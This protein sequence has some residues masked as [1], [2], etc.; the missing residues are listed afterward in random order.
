MDETQQ[1]RKSYTLVQLEAY[2]QHESPYDFLALPHITSFT[3]RVASDELA[4]G[5][6][7]AATLNPICHVHLLLGQSTGE[8]TDRSPVYLRLG[9]EGNNAFGLNCSGR[10]YKFA[11]DNL[12]YVDLEAPFL[13]L[14]KNEKEII[15]LHDSEK[16]RLK[17]WACYLFLK[18]GCIKTVRDYPG[19]EDDLR[20]A[21]A[22]LAKEGGRPVKTARQK[23]A[24]LRQK[25][26]T[27]KDKTESLRGRIFDSGHS[28]Q[29]TH[30][31]AEM[32]PASADFPLRTSRMSS[33]DS[34][35]EGDGIGETPLRK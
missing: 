29:E 21:C 26:S 28:G 8:Y 23:A 31:N 1:P 10:F 22:R 5:D 32:D 19:F 3:F 30:L 17:A 27:V 16:R 35:I 24:A 15:V 12:S 11:L 20:Y 34:V 2:L 14:L 25:E 4:D 6:A 33:H 9:S 7:T 13:K 18:S